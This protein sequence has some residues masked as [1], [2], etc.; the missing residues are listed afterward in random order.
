MADELTALLAP[1]Q[2]IP[3]FPGF[4]AS[5]LT[6]GYQQNPHRDHCPEEGEHAH[7]KDPA[8][9]DMIAWADGRWSGYDLTQPARCIYP[10]YSPRRRR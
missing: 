5:L 1:P 4:I 7:L 8:G 6:K 2:P 10:V 3:D 9:Y